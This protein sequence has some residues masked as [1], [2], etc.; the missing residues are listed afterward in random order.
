MYKSRSGKRMEVDQLDLNGNQKSIWN[1]VLH[2][3]IQNIVEK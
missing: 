1:G 2:P 3:I